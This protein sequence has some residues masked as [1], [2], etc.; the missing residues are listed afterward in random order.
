MS[1]SIS[2]AYALLGHTLH[3]LLTGVIG[4]YALVQEGETLGQ[5]FQRVREQRLKGNLENE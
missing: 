3:I 2:L 1:E 5:L 4:V